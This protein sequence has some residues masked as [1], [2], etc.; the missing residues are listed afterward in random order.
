M[1]KN[2]PL[3]KIIASR[4]QRWIDFYDL[5]K[6]PICMFLIRYMPDLGTRPWPRGDNKSERIEWAWR[7]YQLQMDQLSWLDDDTLPF[8]DVYTGTEIF[9]AAFGCQVYYSDFDMPFALPFVHS[10]AEA[11]A[12]KIPSLDVPPIALLFEIAEELHRRAGPQALMHLVDIQ[13]PMD[14]AALIWDKESYYP[15]L[16]EAPEAVKEL[17]HKIKTFQVRFLEEWFARFGREFIAHYPDYYMPYGITL[18]EDEIGAVSGKVFNQMF[19]PELVELSERFGQMGMHCCANSRHQ[20]DN[21]K[22]IPNLRLLNINQPVDILEEGFEYFK[23]QVAFWPIYIR[24]DPGWKSV[25]QRCS[26]D[27]HL[28]F[29]I[30]V[31]SQ[32]EAIETAEYVRKICNG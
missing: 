21:F 8:L 11:S 7:K 10:A 22:K 27:S 5:E 3:E 26:T 16:I 6:S 13:S 32:K 19:L 31:N 4:K 2:R 18:S 17:S 29:E 1:I 23:G 15:A 28:V 14:V 12:L 24:D 30:A 25:L 9:A 20:W